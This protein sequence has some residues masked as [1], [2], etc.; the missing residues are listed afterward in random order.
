[1]TGQKQLLNTVHV[2]HKI[3]DLKIEFKF[4]QSI[5]N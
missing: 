1:M 2:L 4:N 5:P 3:L